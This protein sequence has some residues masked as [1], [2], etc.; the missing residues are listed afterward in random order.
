MIFHFK[1]IIMYIL[2]M[3][4]SSVKSSLEPFTYTL[5][6]KI[7]CPSLHFE[8]HP[9]SFPCHFLEASDNLRQAYHAFFFCAV[10]S[11]RELWILVPPWLDSSDPQISCSEA[12]SWHLNESDC[13]I[14][15]HLLHVDS[16]VHIEQN[17][18]SAYMCHL[19]V[20]H[21]PS[22]GSR[23]LPHTAGYSQQ[24]LWR[25]ASSAILGDW[26][27]SCPAYAVLARFSLCMMLYLWMLY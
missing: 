25:I 19:A 1:W 13:H 23:T 14:I 17:V 9:P 7:S 26:I 27:S 2:Y 8:F 4:S 22:L 21:G 11:R 12:W 10:A 3:L 6:P 24:H 5:L 20:T 18:A 15:A 16:N